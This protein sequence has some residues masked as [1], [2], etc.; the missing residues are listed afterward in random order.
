MAAKIRR[1]FII[2][3]GFWKKFLNNHSR[4]GGKYIGPDGTATIIDSPYEDQT[5]SKITVLHPPPIASIFESEER[6]QSN[7]GSTSTNDKIIPSTTLLIE[8]VKVE[9]YQDELKPEHAEDMLMDYNHFQDSLDDEY[10]PYDH[11]AQ[12]VKEE[13]SSDDEKPLVR[14]HKK[15][16]LDK[17]DGIAP[18]HG[19]LKPFLC[20]YEECNEGNYFFFVFTI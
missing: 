1:D 16:H 13:F 19:D 11:S 7:L 20:V 5:T 10:P 9:S 12:S 18:V 6:W 3:D 15:R 2:I 8:E 17:T 14:K 4:T